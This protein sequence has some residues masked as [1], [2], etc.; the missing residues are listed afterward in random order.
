LY[1]C[2]CPDYTFSAKPCKHMYRLAVE[3]GILL[4]VPNNVISSSL[5]ALSSLASDIRSTERSVSA[6]SRE[7]SKKQ[8]EFAHL[9][10]ERKQNAP[11]LSAQIADFFRLQDMKIADSLETKRPPALKAAEDVRRI[12]REKQQFILRAKQAEYQLH[13]FYS[14][15]PWLEDYAELDLN[16]SAQYVFDSDKAEDRERILLSR[17]PEKEYL[18]LD[19]TEKTQLALER[20][21]CRSRTNWEAGRD[22]ERYVCYLYEQQGYKVVSNGA[23]NGKEDMGRDLIATKKGELLVIQC[24]WWRDFRIIHENHVFQLYGT[25]V[26]YSIRRGKKATPILYTTTSLSDVARH[27]AEKI[28]VVIFENQPFPEYP[29]IKCNISKTGEKIYHLPFDQ[30][31]DRVQIDFSSG[32]YY[33]KSVAEAEACGFRRAKKWISNET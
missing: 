5:S 6:K 24:K 10:E 9:V 20:W 16:E 3:L 14:L 4:S 15:F 8:S 27:C 11:W 28:G 2:T 22:Y 25:S 31:Y 17:L 33:A 18:A 23:L 29:L 26:E 13:T 12:S 19:S 32:E 1:S 30:Q 21:R 7:L